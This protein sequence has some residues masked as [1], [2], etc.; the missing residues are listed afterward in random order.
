VLINPQ[1]KIVDTQSGEILVE[2]YVPKIEAL[3]KEFDGQGLDRM[4]LDL[5]PERA[6]EPMR[7][8]HYPSK[9]LLGPDRTLFIA[10]TGHHRILQVQ[11][12]D[13]IRS[14]EIIK[15]FGRG[16]PGFLNQRA[17]RIGSAVSSWSS[18]EIL[19]CFNHKAPSV[20]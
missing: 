20:F 11:L 5:C 17:N 6:V 18:C 7:P 19:W 14:G 2:E 16:E 10:D 3:I 15:Q 4:P 12:A 9:L 13:D 1:G 8:L